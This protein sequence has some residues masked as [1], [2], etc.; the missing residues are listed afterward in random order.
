MKITLV[1]HHFPP[2]YLGGVEIY[3]RRLARWLLAH[4]HAVQVV[5]IETVNPQIPSAVLATLDNYEGISVWRLDWNPVKVQGDWR[6][7]H[8]DP[9]LA[10]WFETYIQDFRPDIV[11]F[12]SGYLMGEGP[13]ESATH[14]QIPTILTLHDYWFLCPR[15]TLLRGNGVLCAQIPDD[16]AVC[17][18]CLRLVKRR[19]R[20]M[21]KFSGGWAG[22]VAQSVLGAERHEIEKR[23]AHLLTALAKPDWVI[24]PS[25]FLANLVKSY[26]PRERLAISPYGI[27]LNLFAGLTPRNAE[28]VF[29]IGF[30][31]QITEHKG[32]HLLVQA[33]KLQKTTIRPIEVEIYGDTERD[34]RYTRYL[35]KLIGDDPR[36]TFRGRYE[37][38]RLP[39][40]LARFDV[41][42]VPS[43]WYEIGPLTIK[44]SFAAGVPVVATNLGNMAD[45]VQNDVNGLTFSLDDPEDLARQLTRLIEE[46]GLLAR[47][48]AG[49]VPPLS[50]DNEM[51]KLM[52][53]YLSAIHAHKIEAESDKHLPSYRSPLD[54]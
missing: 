26:V 41:T 29:R 35:Q 42:V 11:H 15:I 22:T 9:F 6:W 49:V 12:H 8:D 50:V 54:F 37:N 23:R 21:D 10:Q 39:Y 4:G 38:D 14:L 28:K 24:A 34:L 46:P 36:I 5:C 53:Y 13:I 44:E 2:K 47:L 31:G 16:P 48:R 25:R 19:F 52:K 51:E 18:W 43:I 1:V 33:L 17:A 30:L 3:T 45:L 20:L 7:R 40:I 32:I 27:D